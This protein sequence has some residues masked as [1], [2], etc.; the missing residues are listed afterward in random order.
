MGKPGIKWTL[1][2]CAALVSMVLRDANGKTVDV[3]GKSLVDV[4]R[5]QSR[6]D[7]IKGLQSW[8]R[9]L[10]E[11]EIAAL[12]KYQEETIHKDWMLNH[13]AQLLLRRN[14]PDR[15]AVSAQ[16]EKAEEL[17]V[18]MR[19]GMVSSRAYDKYIDEIV[20]LGN[21]V[22]Q[23]LLDL[24]KY[25]EPHDCFRK[26]IAI[27]ALGEIDDDRIVPALKDEIAKE[28]HRNHLEQELLAVL[29]HDPDNYVVDY[30]ANVIAGQKS[31]FDQEYI[32]LFLSGSGLSDAVKMRLC[33]HYEKFKDY[34]R[35]AVIRVLRRIGDKAAFDQLVHILQREKYNS[36][37]KV[38]AYELHQLKKYDASAVFLEILKEA[39]DSVCRSLIV[40]IAERNY[41]PA[42][43]VLEERIERAG[44][45]TD[46]MRCRIWAAAALCR[47]GKDYEKNAAIVKEQLKKDDN[48]RIPDGTPYE[49]AKWLLDEET[50]SILITK[51]RT[52]D[53][54][55]RIL[56]LAIKA[57]VH[58]SDRKVLPTLR[59][60]LNRASLDVFAD[61]GE[62]ITAI[63]RKHENPEIIAEGEMV[64]VVARHLRNLGGQARALSSSEHRHILRERE[65]VMAWFRR[66]REV[67]PNIVGQWH[68]EW[69]YAHIVL[70]TRISQIE[71]VAKLSKAEYRPG[72]P[73]E[74]ILKFMNRGTESVYFKRGSI[75]IAIFKIDGEDKTFP[76]S[77]R[78]GYERVGVEESQVFPL[79]SG[80]IWSTAFQVLPTKEE[81]P[82]GQYPMEIHYT[83]TDSFALP[84]SERV[85]EY[86]AGTLVSNILTI[87]IRD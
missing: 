46:S 54:N 63:G 77:T 16:I 53:I 42:I 6:W 19:A 56:K 67:I 66:H 59:G 33:G 8:R 48:A 74:V 49:A 5:E 82:R 34:G 37:F 23:F 52:K 83:V 81:L 80:E 14:V 78:H 76:Q 79:K 38:A 50:V 9:E 32:I 62:A 18:N 55:E 28:E 68:S 2:I 70:L 71:M 51:I 35:H 41:S 13:C 60:V 87:K 31:S 20:S 36:A 11:K 73:I 86:S 61:V 30:V 22:T 40:P 85:R 7:R 43:P 39:P 24:L 58:I 26:R 4:L 21:E 84:E 45:H 27:I 47:L 65:Q 72:E 29:K 57:L 15:Y 17:F 1:I 44:N 25:R 69:N 12:E 10:T 64:Q 3:E 75:P